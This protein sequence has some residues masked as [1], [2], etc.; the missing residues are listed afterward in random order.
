[1]EIENIKLAIIS[2][3]NSELVGNYIKKEFKKESI[4]IESQCFDNSRISLNVLNSEYVNFNP[5][6][7]VVIISSHILYEEYLRAVGENRLY[8]AENC[9]QEIKNLWKI[10][11]TN[12]AVVFQTNCIEIPDSTYGNCTMRFENSFLYQIRKLNYLLAEACRD[13]EGII[14]FD[15]LKYQNRLGYD[16]VFSA[17]AFF[18]ALMPYSLSF[19][20]IFAREW[21]DL[22]KSIKGLIVKCI[23]VDLDNTIWGGIL[24]EDGV[25]ELL[26][27]GSDLGRAFQYF[28]LW[29]KAMKRRGLLLAICS[30][31]DLDQVLKVF[32]ER[33]DMVLKFEDFS[34]CEISWHNKSEGILRISDRLGIGL[35]HMLFIDDS[36]FERKSV[37][38]DFP[39]LIV[40]NMPEDPSE[41]I[42]Y[43]SSFNYFNSNTNDELGENRT[44]HFNNESKRD[45]LRLVYKDEESYLKKLDM[46]V[47]YGNVSNLQADRVS[48]LLNRC[49]RFNLRTQRA[50]VDQVKRL[51]ID[52]SFCLM[53]F[54][55]EDIYEDYGMVSV[56]VGK[57]ITPDTIFIDNWVLSCRAFGRDV[58]KAIFNAFINTMK[59]MNIKKIV[60]EYLPTKKNDMVKDLYLKFGFEICEDR[61]Y[62]L[63][64]QNYSEMQNLISL[65]YGEK[66]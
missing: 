22:Y 33:E 9:V 51:I 64:V 35:E 43:L 15:I 37:K 44:I 19:I 16:A 4:T 55:L 48:Q 29:L 65:E 30:K 56:V 3:C 2:N 12:A 23:V 34:A 8:F 10:I 50:T 47:R 5:S 38:N 54:T 18:S 45:A 26:I 31:N 7:V 17:P 40:P 24:S 53:Y 36:S 11:Q 42:S 1:M 27:S 57:K 25:G 61:T 14:P 62:L 59:Q 28:Q 66:T 32:H 41:Y 58:E 21:F 39:E 52:E 13:N 6:M 20:K 60:G 63:R 46:R 49:N